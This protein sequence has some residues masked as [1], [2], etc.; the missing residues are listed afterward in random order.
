MYILAIASSCKQ[1][2]CWSSCCCVM[3]C[4]RYETIIM[5][6]GISE[7]YCTVQKLHFSLYNTCVR[8]YRND[9]SMTSCLYRGQIRCVMYTRCTGTCRDMAWNVIN[10]I[11]GT[12]SKS[13]CV[14]MY[15]YTCVFLIIS[16]MYG[17]YDG[18][19]LI[20]LPRGCGLCWYEVV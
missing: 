17:M 20:G 7:C 13:R 18:G 4:D 8:W 16:G 3:S 15:T 6:V 1:L 2:D 12:F 9:I 14:T 10:S 5:I 19:S 11:S